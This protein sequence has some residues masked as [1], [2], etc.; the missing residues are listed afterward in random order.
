MKVQ[1]LQSACIKSLSKSEL[2]DQLE[3]NGVAALKAMLGSEDKEFTANFFNGGDDTPYAVTMTW[4]DA[5]Q[6]DDTRSPEFRLYYKP[7]EIMNSAEAGD[8]IVIGFDRHGVL[9]CI[10]YK[11]QHDEHQGNI[12]RWE[13]IK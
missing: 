4:Y 5:R 8:N 10:V 2:Y 7:N 6:N 9:T 13:K 12:S 3:I 11:L 1:A